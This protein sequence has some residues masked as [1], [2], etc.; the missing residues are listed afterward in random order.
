[1]RRTSTVT[2]LNGMPS[3]CA[4]PCC[5]SVGCWV[6]REHVEVAAFARRRERDL[7]FEIEVILPAAA[8]FAA[9]PMRRRLQRGIEI[10]ALHLLRRRDILLARERL[11]DGEDRRQFLVFDVHQLRGRAREIERRRGDRG[12]RLSFMFD[13]SSRAAAARRS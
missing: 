2:A 4:T 9:Q 11:F 5:T 7:A 13:R 6:E 8:E 12:D 10:A 1:M 3:R